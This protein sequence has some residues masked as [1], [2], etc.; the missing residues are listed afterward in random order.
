M[1]KYKIIFFSLACLLIFINIFSNKQ[2]RKHLRI[3][4]NV[5][6]MP[7]HELNCIGNKNRLDVNNKLMKV[8]KDTSNVLKGI[9]YSVYAGTLLHL[10]RDCA[11]AKDTNDIDFVVPYMQINVELVNKFKDNGF[12]VKHTFGDMGVPGFEMAFIHPSGI[13]VD[14]FGEVE[15][16]NYSWTPLWVGGKL[17]KCRF[18]T[19]TPIKLNVALGESYM[20]KNNPEGLLSNLY[21]L[22]WREPVPTKNWNWVNPYCTT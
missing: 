2:E 17:R 12:K 6:I 18:P 20:I 14:V 10:Y 3:N 19:T 22:Q 7:L 8:V 21:G 15:E 13:K 9:D 11:L 4:D 5:S 1:D 16:L